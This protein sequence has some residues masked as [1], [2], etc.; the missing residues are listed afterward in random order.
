MNETSY[1]KNEEESD[2][3]CPFP[4]PPP[5]PGSPLNS[6]TPHTFP[7]SPTPA[8]KT[9][10]NTWAS[11]C[12]KSCM[13]MSFIFVVGSILVLTLLFRAGCAAVN[14]TK[15][16]I[17]SS[18]LQKMLSEDF[19][20]L[21]NL[22]DSSD[23]GQKHVLTLSISGTIQDSDSSSSWY[24]EDNSS[25]AAL[26]R[27]NKARDNKKIQGILLQINSGGGGITASDVVWNS[28]VEFKK[29]DTNRV[30]VVMM[31]SMAASGAYYIAAAAD[32]IVANPTTLTGSI[33]VIMNSFNVQDLATRIG[34]K[35]VTIKSGGNKDILSP[36]TELTPEQELML[37]R[38]VDSLHTRFVNI[39]VEGRGLEEAKVRAIAD[40]RIL[41]ATEAVDLGLIDRVG[42]LDDAKAEMERRLGSEPHYIDPSAEP[43]FLKFFR[44]P[45]F[46][47]ACISQAI[48]ASGNEA[49]QGN[50]ITLK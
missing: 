17:Q 18:S 28:L 36:F 33:G 49:S 38:M 39:V 26:K 43:P 20:G 41:L 48:K 35:S 44:S 30:V 9:P 7:S 19:E 50:G 40:G 27:I 5:F 4:S 8:V 37:Q 23:D 14:R 42:Y 13:M 16:E 1:D 45:S 25:Q 47:G 6:H 32:Y 11:S 2:P 12:L 22:E 46:W 3:S 24:A 15:G 34:L 21:E 10:D 31:G 29:A